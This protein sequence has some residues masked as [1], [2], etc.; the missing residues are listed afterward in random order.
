[1]QRTEESVRGPWTAGPGLEGRAE[2]QAGRDLA[3]EELA[4]GAGEKPSSWGS[5]LCL[6][7]CRWLHSHVP[8]GPRRDD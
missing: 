8:G 4:S 7:S 1:M 2:S 3:P 5:E 6:L